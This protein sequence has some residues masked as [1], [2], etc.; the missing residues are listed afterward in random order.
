MSLPFF[1]VS[2]EDLEEFV[3]I[4][5]V[6]L[7]MVLSPCKLEVAY[8]DYVLKPTKVIMISKLFDRSVNDNKIIAESIA[9]M[10][11]ELEEKAIQEGAKIFVA[12]SFVFRWNKEI[13]NLVSKDQRVLE[14]E[15][16]IGL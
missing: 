13:I 9:T 10:G 12:G 8:R 2:K 15:G 11:R 7:G 16:E 6:H 4:Q 3:E 5:F 1:M 14:L